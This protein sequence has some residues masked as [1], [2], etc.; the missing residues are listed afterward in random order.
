MQKQIYAIVA[1]IKVTPKDNIQRFLLL[2]KKLIK[3]VRRFKDTLTPEE[4]AASPDAV[5][6]IDSVGKTP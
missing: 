1:E 2:R 3:F 5:A 6:L 4:L